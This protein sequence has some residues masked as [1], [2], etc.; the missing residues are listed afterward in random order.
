[1]CGWGGGRAQSNDQ[2][3]PALSDRT[4]ARTTRLPQ[5]PTT[6]SNTHSCK[7]RS[8]SHVGSRATGGNRPACTTTRSGRRRCRRPC[9]R[10]LPPDR[11][12]QSCSICATT[13]PRTRTAPHT[14]RCATAPHHTRHSTRHRPL[15]LSA[16]CHCMHTTTHVQLGNAFQAVSTHRA[17]RTNTVLQNVN[18]EGKL[19][20]TCHTPTHHTQQES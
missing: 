7:N 1:V 10:A 4:R 9:A 15:K 16:R 20:A 12:S 3:L 11:N 13:A 8:N 17:K 2:L 19:V 6:P 5:N 14:S 18:G